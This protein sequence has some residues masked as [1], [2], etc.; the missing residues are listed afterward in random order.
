M[1][2]RKNHL[3]VLFICALFVSYIPS[4]LACQPRDD[5]WISP[6][7]DPK[8]IPRNTIVWLTL[9]FGASQA[10][11][12][13][14]EDKDGNKVELNVSGKE[15]FMYQPNEPL[16]ANTTYTFRCQMC[17]ENGN[18]THCKG[19]CQHDRTTF[20]TG[21]ALETSAPAYT[22]SNKVSHKRQPLINDIPC[23]PSGGS[24]ILTIKGNSDPK[25]AWYE[26]TKLT[27]D[28]K[29]A[30]ITHTNDT[31]DFSLS[32][33]SDRSGEKVCYQLDAI[34]YTGKVIPGSKSICQTL[35]D[36]A[37]VGCNQTQGISKNPTSLLWSLLV[38]ALLFGFRRK[39]A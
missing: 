6:P 22:E 8:N 26:L 39:R 7:M 37:G 34:S 15:V 19:F 2:L 16:K 14:L 30:S 38:F 33:G 21:S 3:I 4:A 12:G 35:N 28:G 20:T 25:V 23:G 17:F 24:H 36:I 29:D 1:A 31:A 9:Y 5:S 10:P 11:K 32:F 13:W 27:K 18:E